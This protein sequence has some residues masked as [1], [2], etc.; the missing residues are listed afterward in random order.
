MGRVLRGV[1]VLGVTTLTLGVWTSPP[2]TTDPAQAGAVTTR[3]AGWTAPVP[4]SVAVAVERLTVGHPL[5]YG[6]AAQRAAQAAAEAEAAAEA[7]AQ[8]QVAAAAAAT[9]A[10]ASAGGAPGTRSTPAGPAPARTG[11]P[12]PAAPAAA[13][14]A[15]ATLP[16]GL[17]P[18]GSAQVVTVVAP[19]ARSTSAQLTAWERGPEGWRPVLGPMTA[20]I[21]SAGI[22][23]A[24]ETTTRTPAG[25]F[26][27][28][29]AFG[30]AGNPGT[31]LPYRLVDG[32]D[33]WV[34]DVRSPR[35]NHYAEC[36][37][38]T[39]D[40]DEAAAENLFDEPMYPQAVVIDYNRGGTPGA[41][42]A[43]FLHVSNGAP[44]AGCVAIDAGSLTALLRWLD[45]AARPL[46]ALGVG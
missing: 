17:D 41:G 10:A 14:P 46:I 25:T 29:E 34:S 40:F 18:G 42:S 13:A 12:S 30:R 37:R 24:S 21:G 27:L 2:G 31:A 16:L 35:Y 9:A 43:F 19:S 20:R 26:S 1:A 39:C 22:G 36:A 45:P 23:R 4:P 8:A 28:T 7:A 32:D 44:T 3:T 11:G 33:W 5:G 15:G 38:G 6:T